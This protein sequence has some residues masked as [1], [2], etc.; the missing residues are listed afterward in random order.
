M[1]KPNDDRPDQRALNERQDKRHRASN[2]TGEP[3]G[4]GEGGGLGGEAGVTSAG[5]AADGGP[6][7]AAGHITPKTRDEPS[8]D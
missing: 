1:N 6:G 7:G 5:D 8:G 4:L 3:G 2:D